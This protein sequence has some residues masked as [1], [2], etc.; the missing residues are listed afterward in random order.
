MGL[1]LVG[2]QLFDWQSIYLAVVTVE[3]I[4]SEE[5]ITIFCYEV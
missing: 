2:V 1:V 4:G 5:P 3:K